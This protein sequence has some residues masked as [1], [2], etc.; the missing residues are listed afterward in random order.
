MDRNIQSIE[1]Y[2]KLIGQKN[3]KELQN[4]ICGLKSDDE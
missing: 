1:E 4:G 2:K 3:L